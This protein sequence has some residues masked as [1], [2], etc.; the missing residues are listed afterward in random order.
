METNTVKVKLW[1]MDVG[2]LSWDKTARLAVFEYDPM[3]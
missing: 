2:Y 3:F 1:G